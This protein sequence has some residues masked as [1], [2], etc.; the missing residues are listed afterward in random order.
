[1]T[2]MGD[3]DGFLPNMVLK[4]ICKDIENKIETCNLS[5][6]LVSANAM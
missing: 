5:I 1:M 4:E 6:A 2:L 3:G